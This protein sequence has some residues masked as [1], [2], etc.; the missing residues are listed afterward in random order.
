MLLRIVICLVVYSS[1][2]IYASS[3]HEQK[4]ESEQDFEELQEECP[5]C[6]NEYSQ[7]DLCICPQG[8]H[9]MGCKKCILSIGN[10]KSDQNRIPVCPICRRNIKLYVKN[11]NYNNPIVIVRQSKYSKLLALLCCNGR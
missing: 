3:S 1:P 7:K 9:L 8:K 10:E 11:L 2:Y 4:N 5:I 6:F